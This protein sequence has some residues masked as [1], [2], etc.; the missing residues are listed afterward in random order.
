MRI[1]P[2]C[3]ADVT[4]PKCPTCRLKCR[5]AAVGAD[6]QCPRCGEPRTLK[7]SVDGRSTRVI[8]DA[9]RG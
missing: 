7:L 4:W 5:P 2:L 3:G 8:R 6:G 9:Y 1:I